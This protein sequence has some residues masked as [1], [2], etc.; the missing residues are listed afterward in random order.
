MSSLAYSVP[1][2]LKWGR[3]GKAPSST[4]LC[5]T[6]LFQSMWKVSE[7][8]WR[9]VITFLVL[10]FF[11]TFIC[12]R[13]VL[14]LNWYMGKKVQKNFLMGLKIW[15]SWGSIFEKSPTCCVFEIFFLDP[16]LHQTFKPIRHL[17]CTFSSCS[18]L[19]IYM[20]YNIY[21]FQEK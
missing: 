16:Q 13:E 5:A 1:M 4:I 7:V 15:S 3:R 17:L 12:F 14:N 21:K 10:Y 9:E 6:S 20:I 18:V 2:P 8:K 19:S 11:G